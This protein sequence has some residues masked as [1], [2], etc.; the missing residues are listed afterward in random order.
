MFDSFPSSPCSIEDNIMTE[1][2]YED[3]EWSEKVFEIS[4]VKGISWITTSQFYCDWYR[5]NSC[6][7]IKQIDQ[8]LR[9]N[10]VVIWI[11]IEIVISQSLQCLFF[12]VIIL[13]HTL[14]E[15]SQWLYAKYQDQG[16]KH[17]NDFQ[18]SFVNVIG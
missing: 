7:I 14:N 9:S 6:E 16:L 12:N 3:E 2:I 10:T 13:M 4:F 11:Q 5:F 1:S 18:I 8:I 15:T 17:Y